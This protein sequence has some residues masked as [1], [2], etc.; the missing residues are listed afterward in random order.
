VEGFGG[1]DHVRGGEQT[2]ACKQTVELEVPFI[3][4]ARERV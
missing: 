3:F 4:V 2:E 1:V